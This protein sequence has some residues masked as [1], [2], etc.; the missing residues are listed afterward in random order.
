VLRSQRRVKRWCGEAART[1]GGQ[2]NNSCRVG[3]SIFGTWMSQ[4]LSRGS[5]TPDAFF[6]LKT[7]VGR[8]KGKYSVSPS[9]T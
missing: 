3:E 5:D 8:E 6:N 4:K 2:G 9:P 1:Q 7:A